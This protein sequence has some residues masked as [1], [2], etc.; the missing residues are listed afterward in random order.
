MSEKVFLAGATGAVGTALVPMLIEAGYAVHGSTR[1]ADR[2]EVLEAQGVH[3]VVVDVFDAQ[4]LH[5]A[6]VRIAPWGVIHQLT[7]LPRDLDPA[8]MAEAAVLN[9]RV[10]IEGTRNLVAAAQAAGAKRLVA[11]S[12]AWAYA[13]G[14]RPFAE[15]WP[16]DTEAEG[17]R[18]IS[19]DG[20]AA[21][22]RSVMAARGMTA[23]VLRYGQ[24]YGPNT[25]TGTPKGPS[26]LHVEAAARAALRALQRSPGGIFNIAEDGAEASSEKAKRVLGWR[27]DERLP[28]GALR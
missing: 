22:E 15:E 11:Q 3:P 19:V 20:V 10:R 21:L 17:S 28:Q 25:S 24:L 14:P 13:P 23:T 26:P 27:A 7:D 8:R 16:L 18:R 5:A 2:A 1:R 12:I 6:L 9:A 4:A